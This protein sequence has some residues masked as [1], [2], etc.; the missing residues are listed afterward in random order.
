MK[1]KSGDLAGHLAS[2]GKWCR[3]YLLHGQHEARMLQ[4]RDKTVGML[5]GPDARDGMR[6]ETLEAAGVVARPNTLFMAMNATSFFADGDRVVVISDA[7][8]ALAA[9]IE[10]ILPEL[11]ADSARMVITAR[12]YLRPASRLRKLFESN[13][14]LAATAIFD[15][16]LTAQD[17]RGMLNDAGLTQVSD[18]LLRHLTARLAE[19]DPAMVRGIIEKLVLYKLDD[20]TTLG[21]DDL[22]ACVP[23]TIAA[24]TERLLKAVANR[25]PQAIGPAF[26]RLT[27]QE[28]NP[29]GLVI[30][31]ETI[32]RSILKVA[33]DPQGAESG[34]RRLRPP[35]FGPRQRQLINQANSWGV[36]GARYA[37]HMLTEADLNLR[38]GGNAPAK[39]LVERT[40]LR[41]ALWKGPR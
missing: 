35:V 37:L 13:S 17:V 24:A 2:P 9:I 19:Y 33:S 10:K 4:L 21:I 8:D 11:D 31:A 38:G 3:A 12:T 14:E 41:I 32:F 5:G 30:Q 1:I 34:T 23:L 36:S 27:V 16:P 40:F 7:G 26:R 20:P 15:N 39:S 6:I 25:Q 22:D 29:V 28:S 18:D